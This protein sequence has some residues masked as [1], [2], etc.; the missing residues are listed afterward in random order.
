MEKECEPWWKELAAGAPGPTTSPSGGN[1]GP[2]ALVAGA[3]LLAMMGL[4]LVEDQAIVAT[5]RVENGALEHRA[6]NEQAMK[7]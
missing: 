3:V 2:V 6:A 1:A 7:I 4:R 5:A